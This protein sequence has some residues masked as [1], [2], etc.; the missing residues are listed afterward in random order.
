MADAVSPNVLLYS[1]LKGTVSFTPTDGSPRD[2]G[3][4]PE[5][6]LTPGIDKLDHFSSRAGTRKKDRSVVR[7]Q[8]LTARIVLDEWTAEN[9]QMALMGGDTTTNTDGTKS[10]GIMAVSEI[11][12]ALTFTGTNDIG[13]K[14]SLVLPNVSFTPSGSLNLISDE[15]GTIE[16]TA[17][18]LYDEEAGD[19]G[20]CTIEV[21]DD[22]V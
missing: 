21:P 10:F 2:L 5:F 17:D 6:E 19:F 22:G 18:V 12:G 3:N 13:S 14:V 15:W 20:T 16:V 1:V 8:T 9:L 4:A 7:E 11:T